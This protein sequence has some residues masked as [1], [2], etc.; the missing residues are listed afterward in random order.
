MTRSWT[1]SPEVGRSRHATD[2]PPQS[3]LSVTRIYVWEREPGTS[4][5]PRVK[6]PWYS[7]RPVG[8]ASSDLRDQTARTRL[9]VATSTVLVVRVNGESSWSVVPMFATVVAKFVVVVVNGADDR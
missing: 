4:V 1:S 5:P 6:W 2:I 9:L 3:Q 8:V 7:A